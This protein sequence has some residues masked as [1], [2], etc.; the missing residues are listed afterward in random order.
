[1]NYIKLII[2]IALVLGGYVLYSFHVQSIE[3][4]TNAKWEKALTEEREKNSKIEKAILEGVRKLEEDKNV[5]IQNLNADVKR[6][7]VSLRKRPSREVIYRNTPETTRACT[8]AGLYRED[9][10]F[11]IGEAARA[12]KIRIERDFYYNQYEQARKKL[13]ESSQSN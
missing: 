4:K 8:G 11:L 2:G 6:L 1:M 3:K 5:K 10:E 9:G 12:N 13:D 7:T